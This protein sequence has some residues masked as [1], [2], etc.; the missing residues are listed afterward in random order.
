M[1]DDTPSV[2]YPCEGGCGLS[3]DGAAIVLDLRRR[4]APEDPVRRYGYAHGLCGDRAREQGWIVEGL[5]VLSELEA[6]R[7]A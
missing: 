2:D 6:Q 7:Q 1:S 5:G 3:L 4:V